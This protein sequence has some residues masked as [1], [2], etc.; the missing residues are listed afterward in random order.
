MGERITPRQTSGLSL[1]DLNDVEGFDK[2][3]IEDTLFGFILNKYGNYKRKE[4]NIPKPPQIK[5]LFDIGIDK[6]NID[7]TDPSENKPL[8]VKAVRNRGTLFGKFYPEFLDS[9]T[10]KEINNEYCLALRTNAKSLKGAYFKD[11]E[12]GNIF[13]SVKLVFRSILLYN[14]DLKSWDNLSWGFKVI[15]YDPNIELV[16]FPGEPPRYETIHLIPG[17]II[18]W[19]Q[20]LSN[21]ICYI[22]KTK[23][24]IVAYLDGEQ[25]PTNH[26]TFEQNLG[27]YRTEIYVAINLSLFSFKATNTPVDMETLIAACDF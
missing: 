15:L 27:Y 21:R 17:L 26:V 5:W 1:S 6:L 2:D 20:D 4:I 7:I 11:T 3:A 8:T 25:E 16:S 9:V 10:I 19:D 12:T 22:Y 14:N 13:Y 23:D 24:N 18:K